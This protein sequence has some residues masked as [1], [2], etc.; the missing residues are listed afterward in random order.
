MSA[1]PDG[2]SSEDGAVVEDTVLAEDAV[3][4]GMV[5]GAVPG[6]GAPGGAVRR[7][8]LMLVENVALA[9]DHR[10]RRQ[11]TALLAGGHEV[12]VICRRDPG[13]RTC[14]PGVRVLQYPSPR[15]GSGPLAFAVVYAY[16]LTMAALLTGW[17]LLRRRVDLVQVASTPDIYFVVAVPLRWLGRRVVLDFRDLSPEIFAARHGRRDGALYRLLCWLE[18]RTLRSADRVLAVNSSLAA[19]ARDRCGVPAERI[20]VVGNGPGLRRVVRREPDPGLRDGHRHLCCWVGVIGLQDRVDLALQAVAQLVHTL[21]RRDTRF[22]FVGAGDALPD[23][24]RQAS[25]L[26]LEPWVS[27]PG[28]VEEEQVFGYLST[29]DVGIEPNLDDFVSPVKVMEYMAAG[30]PFV[31]FDTTETAR[32]SGGAALLVPKGDVV[33]LAR[34]LDDL[35]RAPDQ[36]RLRGDLGQA[37]VAR[38]LAWEHQEKGYLRVFGE[39]AGGDRP[40]ATPGGPCREARR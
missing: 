6:G 21:G 25:D 32:L 1:D 23:V 31:A 8:I 16:S 7:R 24:R 2:A 22:V 19:V 26:G 11:A 12:T 39:L 4:A 28:W 34:A 40:E 3:V 29:A 5:G 36:R 9:R 14:V 30:L 20:T 27:F 15:D 38:V 13:N 10:L 33:A 17:A 18:R 35:L 37:R